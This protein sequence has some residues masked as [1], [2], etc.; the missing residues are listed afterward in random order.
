MKR[1]FVLILAALLIVCCISKAENPR[2]K[3]TKLRCEYRA[4]PLGIDTQNPRLSWV[5]ESN[6]RSQRQT[7]YQVIVAGKEQNLH[8]DYGDLWDSGKVN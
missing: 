2:I 7:C 4:D 3:V 1:C 8:K 5:P 6:V